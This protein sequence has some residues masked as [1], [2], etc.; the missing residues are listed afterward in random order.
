MALSTAATLSS[1]AN[2]SYSIAPTLE[3]PNATPAQKLPLLPPRL[4]HFVDSFG[5][6]TRFIHLHSE[7][8]LAIPNSHSPEPGVQMAIIIP[9]TIHEE[10]L[11]SIHCNANAST[12]LAT[13]SV[14]P[15]ALKPAP[16][17]KNGCEASVLLHLQLYN[18]IQRPLSYRTIAVN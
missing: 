12:I 4:R 9:L 17:P 13:S 16:N 15:S 8:I 11:R 6:L 7:R 10:H 3:A 2:S 1:S 14:R 5:I 18:H